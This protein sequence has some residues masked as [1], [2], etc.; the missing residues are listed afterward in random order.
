MDKKILLLSHDPGGAN[1]IIPLVEPLKKRGYQVLLYG[2]NLALKKYSEFG[3]RGVDI[4]QDL[5]ISSPQNLRKFLLKNPPDFIITG[6]SAEDMTERY[7]WQASSKLGIPSFAV[8]DGW[9]NYGIRFSKYGI[10]QVNLFNKH[11]KTIYLPTKICVMD[12]LAKKETVKDGLDRKKILVTGQPYFQLLL[13]QKTNND[14][15]CLRK[16]L[17]ISPSDFLIVYVSEPISKSYRETEN[18]NHYWGYTEKTIFKYLLQELDKIAKDKKNPKITFLIKLHPREDINSYDTLVKKLKSQPKFKIQIIKKPISNWNLILSANLI[19]GM[20]SMLL[21]EALLL[22]KPILSVQIGLK[23]ENP[24][25]LAKK[26]IV[27]S[28]TD[29]DQLSS[30][31]KHL[32]VKRDKSNYNFKIIKNPVE[33]IISAM[34]KILWQ[35]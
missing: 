10:G 6:T 13:K 5:K 1:T 4:S 9:M 17:K 32:I 26:K 29:S 14:R 27:K 16:K 33:N 3:L 7:L 12:N 30:A 8:L 19:C 23:R 35:N 21:T 18:S 25:I 20:S 28:I 34:E 2:K 15:N 31:L 22:G 11:K 24:F